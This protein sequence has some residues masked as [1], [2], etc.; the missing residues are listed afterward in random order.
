ASDDVSIAAGALRSW[1]E[2]H[3]LLPDAR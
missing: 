1:R 2:R 3:A